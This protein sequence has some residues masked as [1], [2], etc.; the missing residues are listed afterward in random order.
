[1]DIHYA[2]ITWLC[3]RVI[4]LIIK[5]S[6]IFHFT[7]EFNISIHIFHIYQSII[8]IYLQHWTY[9]KQVK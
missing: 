8:K 6:N 2:Y 5:Q 1:M 7:Q 4:R 9:I 3:S